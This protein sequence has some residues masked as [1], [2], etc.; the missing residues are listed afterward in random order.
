MGLVE[1]ISERTNE[2]LK[3]V[4]YLRSIPCVVLDIIDDERI[5]VECVANGAK[6][7][8]PNYSA[9]AVNEGDSCIVY[10]TNNTPIGMTGYIGATT[11]F[12]KEISPVNKIE[13]DVSSVIASESYKTISTIG[14]KCGSVTVVTLFVNLNVYGSA[15]GFFQLKISIDDVDESFEPKQ[16][17]VLGGYNLISYS[18]PLTIPSGETKI[19][20]SCIGNGTITNGDI[21]LCGHGIEQYEQFEPT[22]DEDYIYS[23]EDDAAHTHY[24]IGNK[25]NIAMP[26]ELGGSPIKI[27]GATTFNYSDVTGVYIPDGVEEI[28]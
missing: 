3:S 4:P 10:Y 16:T 23:I 18:A 25:T 17:V 28:K 22:T 5:R 24:Y 15:E 1:L 2:E 13:A 19:V 6:Y 14:V 21:L 27:I 7:V 20:V 12:S 11:N 9:N 8:L 26:T